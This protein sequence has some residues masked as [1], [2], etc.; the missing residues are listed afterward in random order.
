[1]VAAL[2]FIEMYQAVMLAV[3]GGVKEGG[4]VAGDVVFVVVGRVDRW[5]KKGA[6]AAHTARRPVEG[7]G[8]QV[9][10]KKQETG[11]QEERT[12]LVEYLVK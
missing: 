11:K 8:I 12:H 3:V 4:Q 2:Q 9:K 7:L 10:G 6:A 1:M 5:R